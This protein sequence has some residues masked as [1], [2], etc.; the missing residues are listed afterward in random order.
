MAALP[1][2]ELKIGKIID[3]TLAVLELTAGPALIFVLVLTA[4][5]APITY[6]SVGSL[7]PLRLAGGELLKTVVGFVCGFFLLVAM[8]RRT[9]LQSR[10]DQDVFL[11]YLGMSLLSM[12]A[13]MLGMIAIVLPGLFLMTRW[14]IAQ[15]L[16]V[17]Q[18]GGAMA[19]LGES[20]DRTR[21]NEF[22]IFAAAFVVLLLPI[23]VIIAAGSFFGE[24]SLA[25]LVVTQLATSAISM[26]LL[27][28]G[29]A[30]YG[31]IVGK[32]A[33]ATV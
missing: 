30:L 9:G 14:S 28:M 31:L 24:G 25:G 1:T 19:S 4:I 8:V 26:V 20:W 13:V 18:G 2:R 22:P 15:P 12:L 17:A 10:T 21:G 5:N 32:G 3:K 29:T 27:A 6:A 33:A 11:P 7:D 16:L 23:A